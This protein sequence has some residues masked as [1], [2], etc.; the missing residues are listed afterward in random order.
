[1]DWKQLEPLLERELV[2]SPVRDR[3]DHL[4]FDPRAA[5]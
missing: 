2:P 1:M 4:N 3:G 5:E